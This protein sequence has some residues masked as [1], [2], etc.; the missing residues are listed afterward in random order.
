MGEP[1]LNHSRQAEAEETFVVSTF[2]NRRDTRPKQVQTTWSGLIKS[3]CRHLRV[4]DKHAADLW[5]PARFAPG[6]ERAQDN[7]ID[8]SVLAFDIDDGTDASAIEYWLGDLCSVISSSFS[9]T[10]AHPKL[11]VVI[12]LGERIPLADFD[13]TWRRANQHLLHGHVDPSTKDASRMFYRPSCPPSAQPVAIVHDGHALDWRALPAV[14]VARP[15]PKHTP[16]VPTDGSDQEKRAAAL[17]N[18]WDNDLAGMPAD[19]GRHNRL[20]ELARAAGGL[21]A[22]GLLRRSQAEDVLFGASAANGLVAD[23]GEASVQRTIRDGLDR[24]EQAPW[25]PD[26]LPDSP[27]WHPS[28]RIDL[29]N[30]AAIRVGTRTVDTTT[31]EVTDDPDEWPAPMDAAAFYGVLGA[32]VQDV[33][34]GTEADPCAVLAMCLSAISAVMDPHTHMKAGDAYHPIR[35]NAIL[36]G[37][38]ARGRKGTAGKIAEA[39]ARAADPTCAIVE[40]L[41]SGEGLLWAIRDGISKL[42]P[43]TQA[44]VVIDR[45]VADKRLLVMETEF[46]TTLR[47]LQRDGNSLSPIIRRAW[48]LSPDGVLRSITKNSP[49]RS[50]GAHIVIAGHITRRELLRYIDSTELVNGFAN[51]FLW[52]ASRRAHML[53]F[54]EETDRALID[55]FAEYVRDARDWTRGGHRFRW[56]AAARQPWELAYARLGGDGDDLYTSVTARGAPQVMRLCEL[57]A[58]MEGS[59]ELQ[60][61]H[62]AAALAV[63]DY[64]ERTS[65]WIFG[66]ATGDPLADE[67][68]EALRAVGALTRNDIYD[69][70]KRH[71]RRA[72]IDQALGHLLVAGLVRCSKEP[73]SGRPIELWQVAA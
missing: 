36:V 15:I 19:S 8:V 37:P 59:Q 62:L 25:T 39:V 61:G 57:Y 73:T 2:G 40:G 45:G 17:L 30:T 5:S 32:F 50:T 55:N 10:D 66:D 42:D 28:P 6:K 63:W 14:P 33:A 72:R 34:S 58:A 44:E 54:G 21:V 67:I 47:V 9:H 22:S 41:S 4:V 64:V 65:R 13:E 11:R 49:A 7:V 24:G 27:S 71:E 26:D 38:T 20:L 70:F 18:K 12:R 29:G 69:L 23:D 3:L 16:G 60:P 31:G 46:A 35:L 52:F 43:K 51:R 1:E 56:A 68:L 48:D 53:P